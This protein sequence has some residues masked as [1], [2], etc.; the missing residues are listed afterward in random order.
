MQALE[1]QR[2]ATLQALA[3][4][5]AAGHVTTGT[6]EHRVEQTMHARTIAA[7]RDAV[8]DLPPLGTSLLRALTG[9]FVSAEPARRIAFRTAQAKVDLDVDAGPRTYLVGRSRSCDVV[10]ADPAVSRRHALISVRGDR[11]SIRNLASMNGTHV[12]G[13]PVTTAVLRAGDVVT[14]GGAVDALVR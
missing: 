14:F 1:H 11:C 6:L 4:H 9:R 8:W 10:L 13:R 2:D 5:Y 12:N 3:D 7:L